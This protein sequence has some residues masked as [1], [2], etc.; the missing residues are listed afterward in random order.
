MPADDVILLGVGFFDDGTIDN[1]DPI[2]TFDLPDEGPYKALPVL[3][4]QLFTG[5]GPGD[6]HGHGSSHIPA[7]GKGQQR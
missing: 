4:S 6:V 3:G 5:Q 7:I 2:G 1:H